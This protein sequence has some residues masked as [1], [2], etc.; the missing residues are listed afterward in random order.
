MWSEKIDLSGIVTG[1]DAAQE[2]ML[3]WWF[4]HYS[5]NNSY[6]VVFADFGMSNA[7]LE[8]CRK[9]GRIIS[10]SGQFK[11]S[12]FK[13]PLAILNSGLAK[14]IWIDLDCE[15]RG[16]LNPIWQFCDKIGLTLDVKRNDL[17]RLYSCQALATGVV[18]GTHG[19]ELIERWA[20]ECGMQQLRGDQEVLNHILGSDRSLVN[21]M[22]PEYQWLR[23][24]GDKPGVLIMHWTGSNGK[25]IIKKQMGGQIPPKSPM[26]VPQLTGKIKTKQ[27][28]KTAPRLPRSVP[29]QFNPQRIKSIQP[30][31][32]P[33]KK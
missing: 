14:F 32:K 6:P 25:T 29:S 22:P 8:F 28:V 19:N 2:W 20:D 3:P 12:W 17:A 33:F 23:L 9:R 15:I 18:C 21:I 4:E 13:K 10:I 16:D 1:C 27:L 7:G 5:K 30:R 31:L 11:E 26:L 24:Q